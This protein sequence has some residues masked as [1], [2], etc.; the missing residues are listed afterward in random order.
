[1]ATKPN[2]ENNLI[3]TDK[4]IEEKSWE[5]LDRVAHEVAKFPDSLQKDLLK[6]G[7][8]LIKANVMYVHVVNKKAIMAEIK[9]LAQNKNIQHSR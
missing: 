9:D 1:M 8:D 2:Q 5:F 3:L 7:K 6:I 4:Q